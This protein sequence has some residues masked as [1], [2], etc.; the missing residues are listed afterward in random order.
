M[1]HVKQ[2]KDIKLKYPDL[3]IASH[4]IIV[5]CNSSLHNRKNSKPE[6]VFL[7]ILSAKPDQCYILHYLHLKYNFYT[8]TIMAVDTLAFI[9]T[10]N[11]ALIK[12]HDVQSMLKPHL[13]IN[14][15]M[16]SESLFWV[17]PRARYTT[18]RQ[19]EIYNCSVKASYHKRKIL[20]I[21]WIHSDDNYADDF[22]KLYGNGALLNL[23][24]R[25]RIDH[26]HL[27]MVNRDAS[28]SSISIF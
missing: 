20:N 23:P 17:L 5:Y 10:F 13:P 19:L 27:I 22:T 1:K 2:T 7:I 21:A 24:R 12:N 16:D 3:D 14:M 26:K 11:H 28:T 9:D 6:R 25:H 8:R 4:N 18:E 15:L